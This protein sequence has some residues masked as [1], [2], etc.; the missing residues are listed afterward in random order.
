MKKLFIIYFFALIPS[1]VICQQRKVLLE[2][3]TG[4]YCSNCPM[5]NYY[6]DSMLAKH[7]DLIVVALHAYQPADAMHFPMLDS[8]YATYS[9]GAPLA[10]IDRIYWGT[11]VAQFYNTWDSKIQQRLAV[12]PSVNVSV[13]SS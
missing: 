10:A 11:G 1:F 9:A 6:S 13:S 5:G 8:L 3:F 4:A 12:T 7:P 2:E